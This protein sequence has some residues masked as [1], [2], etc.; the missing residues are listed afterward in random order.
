MGFL[1]G[2]DALWALEDDISLSVINVMALIKIT[3]DM[4]L[5]ADPST[6]ILMSL[7]KRI[8]ERLLVDDME[9]PKLFYKRCKEHGY[10]FWTDENDCNI[11]EFI[12]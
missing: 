10:S 9:F 4:Q 12:R 8:S 3:P 1:E 6:E 2:T 7:R 5:N 11:E